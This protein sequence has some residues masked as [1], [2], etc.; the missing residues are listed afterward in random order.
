MLKIKNAIPNMFTLGNLAFGILSLIM[1][2][3]ENYRLACYFIIIS[4]IMDR[5]DGRLAR[6]F[7]VSS[8]LGKEL[9]SLADLIS[10]GVAP[11]ILVFNVNSFSQ[12]GFSGYLLALIF[13]IAGAYRLARYNITDFDGSFS[14]IPITIAGMLLSIYTLLT[15]NSATNSPTHNQ[16]PAL[17]LLILSY[18][19]VCNIKI[20]KL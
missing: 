20:K 2:F 6:R 17:L 19:M 10:F 3:Q 9:D 7:N 12:L 8:D 16:I 13:P 15:L 14:G 11:S 4:A 18:L 1:S 5:Y